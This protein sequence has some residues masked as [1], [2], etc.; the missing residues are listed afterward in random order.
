MSKES[1]VCKK[2]KNKPDI[3]D[4]P[5][6]EIIDSVTYRKVV[7]YNRYTKNYEW[8]CQGHY[9]ELEADWLAKEYESKKEVVK[10]KI[11]SEEKLAL[12]KDIEYSTQQEIADWMNKTLITAKR[13]YKAWKIIKTEG[14]KYKLI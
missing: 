8:L 10:K 7:N 14:G 3:N 9:Y 2:C 5:Y 12:I 1:Y 13:M 4:R 6:S 11:I